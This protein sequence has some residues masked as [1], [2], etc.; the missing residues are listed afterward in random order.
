MEKVKNELFIKI[1]GC[2]RHRN[3]FI[4]KNFVKL[5]V[6]IKIHSI[7]NVKIQS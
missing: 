4:E 6:R 1:K 2:V 3:Y 7:L 5:L